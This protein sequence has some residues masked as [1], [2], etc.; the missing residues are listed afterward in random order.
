MQEGRSGSCRA[1]KPSFPA[2]TVKPTV[3]APAVQWATVCRLAQTL[4]WNL[5]KRSCAVKRQA[6][7]HFLKSSLS[8]HFIQLN[9]HSLSHTHTQTHFET[10][11][12]SFLS[13]Y[14]PVLALQDLYKTSQNCCFRLDFC[15]THHC[16]F[17][18]GAFTRMPKG[19]LWR[20]GG[21]WGKV[22]WK[23]QSHQATVYETDVS[24]IKAGLLISP[25]F[26]AWASE[27]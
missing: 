10:P 17:C 20:A 5:L 4:D 22:G 23:L 12:R 18:C 24:S 9:P 7:Q 21:W 14:P 8:I 2:C 16:V 11:N 13:P 27:Q 25:H 6:S 15:S 1:S 3:P 19:L 26:F